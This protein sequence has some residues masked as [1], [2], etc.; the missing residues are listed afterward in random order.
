MIP[1]MVP[2]VSPASFPPCS[3][4]AAL[5]PQA[6]LAAQTFLQKMQGLWLFDI[7][8]VW[9]VC[10]SPGKAAWPQEG[11]GAAAGLAWRRWMFSSPSWICWVTWGMSQTGL[12]K[13]C[14]GVV[15]DY[16]SLLQAGVCFNTILLLFTLSK[17]SVQGIWMVPSSTWGICG[18]EGKWE[19]RVIEM[20]TGK[21]MREEREIR[22]CLP[23]TSRADSYWYYAHEN[24]WAFN[25]YWQGALWERDGCF[26]HNL[27]NVLLYCRALKLH[28]GMDGERGRSGAKPCDRCVPKSAE[29]RDGGEGGKGSC[30]PGQE[31]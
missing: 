15:Y 30:C 31:F 6:L 16:G 10:S 19:C 17:V 26:S 9:L 11:Q 28:R 25:P 18:L 2:S 13:L 1:L 12:W 7:S 22:L 14:L 20:S 29:L 23:G 3:L 8:T 21:Y 5:S 27:T 24:Q 4:S